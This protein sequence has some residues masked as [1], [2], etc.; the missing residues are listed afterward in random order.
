[1][2]NVLEL[3]NI[4]KSFGALEILRGIDMSLA[5]GESTAIVGPSGAGKSTLLHIAGIMER[6][7][8]GDV[9]LN[10]RNLNGLSENERARVRLDSIGFLF[11]FHYLL[12]DFDVLENVLVPGR[13]A[14]DDLSA[15][16]RDALA[17]LEKL[18][19]KDRLTHKPN[20][21]SGGEQQRAALARAMIRKPKLLMCDEPTGNLDPHTADGVSDLILREV[22]EAGVSAI[23]VT[24][25]MGLAKRVEKTVYLSEGKV[26]AKKQ[27]AAV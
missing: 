5:A 23:I 25:N 7:T 2:A 21:L 6:P 10:G 15:V 1:M 17:L 27:E 20:Q 14:G 8:T 18:G 19:L 22:K 3:K 26:S 9:L 11:Q 13:L 4:S 24:H 12:P 16:R